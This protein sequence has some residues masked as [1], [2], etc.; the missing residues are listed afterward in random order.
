MSHVSESN[1]IKLAGGELSDGQRREIED[2]LKS[3]RECRA[4]F[5]EHQ[6]IRAAL[7]QWQVDAGSRDL[8]PAIDERLNDWQMVIIR[9]DWTKVTRVS[10]VAAAIA[11][12]VG[13]G[14]GGARFA[15]SGAA[16]PQP[17]LP[18][19]SAEEALG[20]LGFYVVESPSATGLFTT[21]FDL[22]AD[23]PEEGGTP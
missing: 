1:L 13:L 10:R 21:V 7:R 16:G 22:M 17:V 8:W 9:P 15:A 23:A 14:Y 19:V 18:T 6:A 2:H 5:E 4:A 11:L 12:G 20:T 3:C